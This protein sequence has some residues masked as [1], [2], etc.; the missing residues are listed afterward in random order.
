MLSLDG[1]DYRAMRTLQI[2]FP[3]IDTQIAAA[4]RDSQVARPWRV[5]SIADA[6][7]VPAI[8]RAVTLISH[9][10]AS[11]SVQGFRD[12]LVMRQTPTLL[13]RPDPNETPFDFY[14]DSTWNMATAGEVVWLIANRDGDNNPSALVVVP[15][16][17]LQVERNPRNRL[18]T[19][20]RWGDIESTRYSTANKQGRF[21][22]V[23]YHRWPGELRGVGP[24][25]LAKAAVSVSVESQEWAANFY[26]EGGSGGT[27]IKSAEEVD[28]NEAAKLKSQW[29][30]Q[31]NNVPRVID[32]G[33]ESVEQND[34]NPQ[35]AQMLEAREHQNGDAARMYGIP[36]ALLEFSREGAS[37]TY[38]N[39]TDL[40][41]LFV[42]TCLAPSYLEPMEQ[43][44]SDLMPRSTA[45]RFNV[46][47]FLRADLKTR[48]EVYKLAVDVLG[49][50]DA[51][52]MAREQEGITSGD[53]EYASVPPA[54]P[55]AVPISLPRAASRDVRCDGTR[56]LHGKLE[57]CGRLLSKTGS[58]VGHCPRCKK[59]Y[60]AA[61]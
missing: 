9:T 46:R 43:A 57:Q 26:A 19:T 50:D 15:L 42:K 1:V 29:I 2:E 4:R 13:A 39:V 24:L 37:L 51:A 35:G 5:P 6:L 25:Q 36:G 52:A 28:E 33:I 60:P 56:M 44:L 31:P 53:V 34:V 40:F 11:L 38:Q 20:Y 27:I 8:Q 41:T 48:W 21:V 54:P 59:E 58:Y 10:G 12:G 30:G 3:D 32:P 49:A 22:H 47:G 16:H 14:R 61:A 18:R 7:G 45:A 17:E 23:F 55:S